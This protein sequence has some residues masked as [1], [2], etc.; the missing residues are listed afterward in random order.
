MRFSKIVPYGAMCAMMAVVAVAVAQPPA[1]EVRRGD[2]YYLAMGKMYLRHIHDHA[3]I[4]HQ[5][6]ALAQPVPD[7]VLSEHVRE[8]RADLTSAKATYAKL[9]E[10]TKTDA[11]SAK[12]L[13]DVQSQ[14]KQVASAI[15]QL[16]HA[17]GALQDADAKIILD[18]TGGVTDA[19]KTGHAA[20][21]EIHLYYFPM[22]DSH[23]DQGVFAN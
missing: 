5:Y 9:S 2:E 6:A 20:T 1:T 17:V 21:H 8:M 19:A 23:F 16:E 14:L 3:Q 13:A 22:T 4:L 11:T 12:K 15:D 7:D 18:L 10:K